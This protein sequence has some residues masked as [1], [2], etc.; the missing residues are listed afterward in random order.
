LD[1]P[2][3]VFKLLPSVNHLTSPS[4]LRVSNQ[5]RYRFTE[6]VRLQVNTG[7]KRNSLIVVGVEEHETRLKW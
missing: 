2:I 3:G 6:L 1:L 5:A 7:G 4:V